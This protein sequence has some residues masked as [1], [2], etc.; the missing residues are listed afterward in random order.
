MC[1][2]RQPAAKRARREQN[3]TRVSRQNMTHASRTP[4]SRRAHRGE[5]AQVGRRGPPAAVRSAG[6]PGR[7][8]AGETSTKAF[9]AVGPGASSRQAGQGSSAPL[10]TPRTACDGPGCQALSMPPCRGVCCPCIWGLALVARFFAAGCAL[11]AAGPPSTPLLATGGWPRLRARSGPSLALLGFMRLPAAC[12]TDGTAAQQW[13]VRAASRAAGA[14]R[15]TR[16]AA[17][18]DGGSAPWPPP[19]S[20]RPPRPRATPLTLSQ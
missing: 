6:G 8:R 1:L 12:H 20:P 5:H 2:E 4:A 3:M 11:G 19:R 16:G 9:I 14:V 17:P 18:R 13:W 10:A 7:L 15:A